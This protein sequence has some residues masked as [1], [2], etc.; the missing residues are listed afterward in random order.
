MLPMTMETITLT[1]E[2][3]VQLKKK[4]KIADDLLL[5]LESSLRDLEAGRIER[6][7]QQEIARRAA[8][9]WNKGH[10]FGRLRSTARE[11]LHQ[12]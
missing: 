8:T 7:Q 6:R 4:E 9:L 2:R 12:R 10:R 11:E 3:Y 5:Q 1:E